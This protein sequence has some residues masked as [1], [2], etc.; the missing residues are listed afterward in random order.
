MRTSRKRKRHSGKGRAGKR[1]RSASNDEHSAGNEDDVIQFTEA[2]QVDLAQ[3]VLGHAKR[4]VV[5]AAKRLH[6]GSEMAKLLV[7]EVNLDDFQGI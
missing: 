3:A 6:L 2:M 5:A 7:Q 1:A 4:Q